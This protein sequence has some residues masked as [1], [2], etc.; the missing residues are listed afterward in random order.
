MFFNTHINF[1][2]KNTPV[3]KTNGQTSVFVTYSINSDNYN[4]HSLRMSI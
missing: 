1:S 3:W 2:N 4:Q